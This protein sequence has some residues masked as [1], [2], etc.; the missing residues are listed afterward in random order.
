MTEKKSILKIVTSEAVCND[1]P[2]NYNASGVRLV[3]KGDAVYVITIKENPRELNVTI[4]NTDANTTTLLELVTGTTANLSVGDY[5]YNS[6]NVAVVNTDVTSVIASVINTTAIASN[7]DVVIANGVCTVYA[8]SAVK[9]LTL[10][11]NTELTVAKG[12]TDWVESNETANV[13]ATGVS[14]RG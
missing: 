11:P 13:L 10:L 1:T 6:T 4:S 3:N 7:V 12:A 9:T 14:W 8:V 5:L 2:N